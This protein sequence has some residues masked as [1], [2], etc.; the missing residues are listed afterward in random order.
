M[1][2]KTSTIVL[3]NEQAYGSETKRDPG[4]EKAAVVGLKGGITEQNF[5]KMWEPLQ[6]MLDSTKLEEAL[7]Y[8]Q[9]NFG[10]VITLSICQAV[11]TKAKVE[12]GSQEKQRLFGAK[13]NINLKLFSFLSTISNSQFIQPKEIQVPV[14]NKYKNFCCTLVKTDT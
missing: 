2:F 6:N 8:S 11:N 10:K 12:E 5:M 4:R 9:N 7:D 13:S 14:Q 3:G 1:I